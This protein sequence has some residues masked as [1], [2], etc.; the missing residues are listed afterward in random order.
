M[1]SM[2]FSEALTVLVLFIHRSSIVIFQL[3]TNPTSCRILILQKLSWKN[4]PALELNVEASSY[5]DILD[6]ITGWILNGKL[7]GNLATLG[8]GLL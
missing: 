7:V 1:L 4:L 3:N 8:D 6:L 5:E 2:K